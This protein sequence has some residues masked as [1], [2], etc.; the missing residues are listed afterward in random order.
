M[1]P[2]RGRVVCDGKPVN[3]A[4]LIFS[5][6]PRNEDATE[7]GKPATGFTDAEGKYVLS[8]HRALDGALVGQHRV[9]VTLDDA[10]LR[11]VLND[12]A[13]MAKFPHL[14]AAY[15]GAAEAYVKTATCP[16][17][18]RKTRSAAV[19]LQALRRAVAGM[20]GPALLELKAA[21]GA[22]VLKIVGRDA[23]NRPD[24]VHV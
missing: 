20:G 4:S 19:G 14:K 17:C 9:T 15:D 24:V 11:G 2:V 10:R 12:A 21:L 16:P 7:A 8:T 22:D 18:A 6:V 13:L 3:Q 1:A 5:P 23:N